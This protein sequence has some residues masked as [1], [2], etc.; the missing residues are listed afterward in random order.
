LFLPTPTHWISAAGTLPHFTEHLENVRRHHI[1]LEQQLQ[2][3]VSDDPAAASQSVL[4]NNLRQVLVEFR[5][6]VDNKNN[7]VVQIFSQVHCTI[8]AELCKMG[9]AV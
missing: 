9:S 4:L 1:E 3:Q 8:Q 7:T 6:F 5:Y 2:K